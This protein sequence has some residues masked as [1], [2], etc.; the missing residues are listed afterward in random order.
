MSE[1]KLWLVTGAGSGIGAALVRNL[2]AADQE[3]LALDINDASGAALAAETGA[4]FQ[5]CDVSN[6]D[7]WD[8]VL[9]TLEKIGPPD[10]IA[11]NAGI[12]IAPPDAPLSEYQFSAMTI[13]RYR[14]MM[15]V[16]VDGVVFGLR[17]L[18]P[19]L[20][21]GAAIVVTASLAGI[22]P[23][24]V[25]P[26]YTL[27]KHAVVGL[28]RSLGEPLADQGIRINAICP[29]GI[30][31]GIIPDEQRTDEAIFM[32]P[33]CIAE[34]ICRLMDVEETGKTWAKV[35]EEKPAFI[36]RAPGDRSR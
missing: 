34:E 9:E 26:L 1:A 25:D 35:T 17:A 20:G 3:V 27:S 7:D 28:V 22:T 15:G 30:D 19:L 8:R 5:R 6:P 21:S 31:T 12:Q 36:V 14:R 2:R 10:R 24:S 18:L 13:E 33:A 11:L 4:T 16:N 32:T 23:Y 29:G